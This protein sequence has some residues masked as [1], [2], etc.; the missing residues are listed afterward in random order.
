[1][2]ESDAIS[3]K[4][5]KFRQDEK[6]LEWRRRVEE[7]EVGGEFEEETKEDSLL[8]PE[9]GL[10]LER[11]GTLCVVGFSDYQ[12]K[13]VRGSKIRILRQIRQGNTCWET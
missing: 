13:R 5:G 12:G 9:A 10:E 6:F 8:E 11:K 7:E 4:G 1:M 3:R 2:G